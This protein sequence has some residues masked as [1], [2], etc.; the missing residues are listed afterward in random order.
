MSKEITGESLR[1]ICNL[2]EANIERVLTIA[3]SSAENGEEFFLL[4]DN[5]ST[6]QIKALTDRGINVT[7]SNSEFEAVF[8]ISW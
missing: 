3:L 2:V 1:K 8:K 7:H 5:L 6:K 4:H